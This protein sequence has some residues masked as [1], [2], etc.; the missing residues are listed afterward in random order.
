VDLET[1]KNNF[2]KRPAD[3]ENNTQLQSSIERY[4]TYFTPDIKESI[5]INKSIFPM[6][7]QFTIDGV[8]GFKYGDVLSFAGLPKR[9]TDSFV[10]C[11]TSIAHSV[12]NDGEW[13]T[14]IS[15]IPRI[16]I[17]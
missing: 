17:K 6:E 4:V 12:S 5:R 9:Y 11:V 14:Q 15:C 3:S 1:K 2:A 7:L 8:N 13:T 10:F 16:R